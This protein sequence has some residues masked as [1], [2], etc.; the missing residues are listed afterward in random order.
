M[1]VTLSAHKTDFTGYSFNV[2]SI[3]KD[4]QPTT[5]HDVTTMLGWITEDDT[6]YSMFAF[7]EDRVTGN[8]LLVK[9]FMTRASLTSENSGIIA[10]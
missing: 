9:D 6:S 7:V 10:I 5:F 8:D 2:K 3:L 1:S 4:P